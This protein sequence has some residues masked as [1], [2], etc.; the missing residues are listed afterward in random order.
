MEIKYDTVMISFFFISIMFIIC[1][2]LIYNLY[3]IPKQKQQMNIVY[4]KLYKHI[5]VKEVINSLCAEMK[6]CLSHS[7]YKIIYVHFK[8]QKPSNK[9][10]VDFYNNK[11]FTGGNFWWQYHSI[12]KGDML[13][14]THQRKLFILKMI[15]ITNKK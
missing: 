8:M 1:L 10:N 2:T 15:E 14:Y 7:E 12:K 3:Y 13:E 4:K 11:Y 5:Q 6:N 9:I